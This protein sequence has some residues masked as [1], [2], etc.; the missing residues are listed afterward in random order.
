M[1]K[2]DARMVGSRDEFI[3]MFRT[4]CG[5]LNGWEVWTNLMEAYACTLSN[6]M[7]PDAKRKEKREKAY[8]RSIKVL[9][10][11]EKPAE[12]FACLTM[13]LDRNPN[14][15]FLGEIFMELGLGS[16]WHG[17]FFT[18]FNV[19]Q[20]MAEVGI[21]TDLVKKQIDERGWVSIN[22]PSCGAGSTL[23][24]AC[25]ALT[26]A[27]INYQT[28]ALFI[29][30]DI[31]PIAAQM[32]YIQLSL[33]GCAGYV[34]VANTLTDPVTGPALFPDE[35]ESQTIWYTPMWWRDIWQGRRICYL[36]DRD[37]ERTRKEDHENMFYIDFSKWKEA[38]N[39]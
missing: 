17:Q 28:Q 9:G 8:E 10:G 20:M 34:A 24:G 22:D 15:D 31:D 35:K 5:A 37:M 4:M 21:D 27:H 33:L 18:P 12:M 14:Q 29:A 13:A 38:V 7:D 32:C 16:S 23:I 6:A 30:N 36:M 25:T 26:R 3:K 19:S 2:H 11:V 39:E 1:A